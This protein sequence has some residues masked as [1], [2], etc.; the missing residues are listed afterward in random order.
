MVMKILRISLFLAAALGASGLAEAVAS[1]PGAL[2]AESAASVSAEVDTL[3]SASGE[4]LPAGHADA[5]PPALPLLSEQDSVR[6]AALR[7]SIESEAQRVRQTFVNDSLTSIAS[8]RCALLAA[9]RRMAPFVPASDSLC[10]IAM[11]DTLP[12]RRNAQRRAIQLRLDSLLAALDAV[13]FD[14]AVAYAQW[15]YRLPIVVTGRVPADRTLPLAEL[16]NRRAANVAPWQGLAPTLFRRQRDYAHERERRLYAYASTHLSDMRFCRGNSTH[17]PI[18]RRKISTHGLLSGQ[19]IRID[20]A[21][22]VEYAKMQVQPAVKTDKW[23]F[24]GQHQLQVTQTALTDNWYKGGENNMT[25]FTDT[26]LTIKRYDERKISTFETTFDLRLSGYYTTADTVHEMR[27]SDNQFTWDA[28][29]GYKAWRNWYYSTNLYAKTPILEYFAANSRKAK[30]AFLSPFELNIGVGMDYKYEAKDKSVTYSLMLA[31]VS[32]NLKYV[33]TPTRVTVTDY[34]IDADRRALNQYGSTLTSKLDWKITKDISWSSRLYLFTS[35]ES[36]LGEFENTFNFK[37]NNI[38]TA[39]IYAY[40]RFDDSKHDE[41]WQMKEQ[42]TF[43][44]NFI[45]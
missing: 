1:R 27:V 22:G 34:G 38:V 4:T 9:W 11:A 36:V 29:Y 2:P 23:H 12:A 37:V 31:P 32:Y 10:A 25:I 15:D 17:A 7:D 45:W 8:G 33:H 43:G 21:A 42:L 14:S 6:I 41:H 24:R 19:R 3:L 44:F 18:D 30:S 13:P 40:P 5:E 39:M 28:K 16:A 26:K 20:E 35:Y